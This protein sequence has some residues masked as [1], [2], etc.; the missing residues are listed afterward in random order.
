VHLFVS[1]KNPDGRVVIL[2]KEFIK[3]GFREICSREVTK[4]LGFRVEQERTP[5]REE[6]LQENRLCYLDFRFLKEQEEHGVVR[7]KGERG[8]RRREKIIRLQHLISLGLCEEQGREEY[9]LR[10]DLEEVLGALARRDTLLER[11][12][13]RGVHRP[14]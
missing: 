6:L 8:E 2:P 9:P 1:G 4:Y 11:L 13:E 7:L 14:D 10:E 5:K 12:V 3:R